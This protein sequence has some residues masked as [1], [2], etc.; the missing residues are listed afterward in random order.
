MIIIHSPYTNSLVVNNNGVESLD[1]GNVDWLNVS[2]KLLLGILILVSLS[3][4]SDSESVRS[5]LDT[6]LPDGYVKLWVKSDILGS[7]VESSKSSNLSH[8]LWGTLLELRVDQ[9]K[10]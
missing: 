1:R 4:D 3:G 10:S 2:E 5:S 8:G 9:L 7:H 6:S